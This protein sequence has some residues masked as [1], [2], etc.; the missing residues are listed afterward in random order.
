M[1]VS[2]P[3]M[4]EAARCERVALIQNG[5]ILQVD[6]PEAIE[7]SFPYELLSVKAR[8]TYR[9]LTD[10][11]EFPHAHSVFPF[12]DSVHFTDNRTSARPEEVKEF[13]EAR[14]HETVH[15]ATIPADIEDAFMELMD[16]PDSTDFNR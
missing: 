5:Q 14:G 9:L 8:D 16:S 2:T 13:L 7:A 15:I 10:L 3:Y 11:R 1:F 12:G 4:D 6:T